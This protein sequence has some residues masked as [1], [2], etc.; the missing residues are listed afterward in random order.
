MI[1]LR[2]GS[3]LTWQACFSSGGR[4]ENRK[5]VQV[6]G[7]EQD[8][9]RRGGESARLS[10]LNRKKVLVRDVHQGA[11]SLRAELGGRGVGERRGDHK[12][13]VHQEGPRGAARCGFVCLFVFL[14]G[15][16]NELTSERHQQSIDDRSP[17]DIMLSVDTM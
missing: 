9:G 2:F 5:S 12:H 4:L 6:S 11:R 7:P 10:G 8:G 17:H 15:A 1:S 13:E 14:D 3:C 16:L